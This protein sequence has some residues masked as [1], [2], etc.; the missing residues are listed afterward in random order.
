LADVKEQGMIFDVIG[1]TD[2]LYLVSY[3]HKRGWKCNC[4]DFAKRK[5]ACK[6]IFFVIARVLKAPIDQQFQPCNADEQENRNNFGTAT[7]LCVILHTQWSTTTTITNPNAVDLP[8]KRLK[9]KEEKQLQEEEKIKMVEQQPFVGE[10]CSICY[11]TFEKDDDENVI[12]C[13][14]QCG[15]TLHR[16][17]FV[18]YTKI[19]RKHQCPNCRAE[20]KLSVLVTQIKRQ[21]TD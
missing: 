5:V 16:A 3:H 20:C 14:N 7:D 12:Y 8:P 9:R 4:P 17:C 18:R 2:N 13:Y 21:K 10:L 19:S 6:H 1:T 15:K 11:D